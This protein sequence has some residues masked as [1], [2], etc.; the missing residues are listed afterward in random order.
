MSLF[1]LVHH[2]FCERC[3]RE[4]SF[5][6]FSVSYDGQYGSASVDISV[7]DTGDES[8]E[9]PIHETVRD[10]T[11]VL[12]SDDY[13]TSVW[14]V[15]RVRIVTYQHMEGSCFVCTYRYDRTNKAGDIH[16]GPYGEI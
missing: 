6:R 16:T 4:D 15:R 1:G 12:V 11:Q 2:K 5:K 9:G 14:K 8:M 10:S 13:T 7:S 3:S